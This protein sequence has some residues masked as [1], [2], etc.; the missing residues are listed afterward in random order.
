MTTHTNRSVCVVVAAVVVLVGWTC[1]WTRPVRAQQLTFGASAE[2]VRVDVSV[3]RGGRPVTGLR[4]EDFE[5]VDSGV[6]QTISSLSFDRWPV[7]VTIVLDVSHSVSGATLDQLRRAVRQLRADMRPDDRVR[8]ITFNT[9]IEQVIEAG[10]PI[11]TVDQAFNDVR[12]VGG[13]MVFD[14]LAVALASP[15]PADRRQLVVIFSD[16]HDSGSITEPAVL[17]DVAR[18]T[19]PT[20][21][22]VIPGPE[23]IG[24]IGMPGFPVRGAVTPYMSFY[25][26]LARV[27]GGTLLAFS[28][29]GLPGAF[30][31]I[32][33]DFRA[34]YVLHFVPEGVPASGVHDLV[35]NVRRSGTDVRARREYVV[36]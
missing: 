1:D 28:G 2:A 23:M 36:R 34:S 20:V 35:V 6:P 9:R 29:S 3:L 30:R 24:P 7:D 13:S 27:T 31:R 11:E 12:A 8:V 19:T 32:L 21:A 17:L 16:G 5:I 10:S 26:E 22:V 18:R 33:D 15:A 14:T 4:A 25:R